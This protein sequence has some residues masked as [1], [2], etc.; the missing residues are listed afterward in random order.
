MYRTVQL[1]LVS[2]LAVL[3][4]LSALSRRFPHV[5]WLQVFRYDPPRLSEEQ[6]AR[7][8]QRANIQAGLE[9]ILLGIGLPMLYVAGTVMFFNDF[10][11]VATILVVAGSAL[12]LGLGVTGIW[13]NR[14]S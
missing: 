13:R 2:V 5:D 11:A 10:T 1:V 9:L 14:R 4:G 3:Y 8:R 12:C 6:R 7:R